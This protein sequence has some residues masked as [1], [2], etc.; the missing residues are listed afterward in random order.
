VKWT[1]AT[2]AFAFRRAMD[3]SGKPA[4]YDADQTPIVSVTSGTHYA[5]EK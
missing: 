3:K 4:G 1:G 5:I 2:G